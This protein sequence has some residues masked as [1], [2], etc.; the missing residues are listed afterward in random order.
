MVVGD[1]RVPVALMTVAAFPKLE[2]VESWTSYRLN[3][4]LAPV[5]ILRVMEEP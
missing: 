2:L 1:G 4:E 5:D 3:S